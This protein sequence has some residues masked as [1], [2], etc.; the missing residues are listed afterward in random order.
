[1]VFSCEFKREERGR[2]K[3]DK[4]GGIQRVL[5]SVDTKPRI[6]PNGGLANWFGKK[7]K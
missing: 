5:K 2:E 4:N 7:Y 6:K 1:V 3:G